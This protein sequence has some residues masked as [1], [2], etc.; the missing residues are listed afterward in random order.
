[1]SAPVSRLASGLIWRCCTLAPTTWL[2]TL[3]CIS[4]QDCDALLQ[5]L[6]KLAVRTA[7]LGPP[8]LGLA[9]LF[10]RPYARV[11]ASRSRLAAQVFSAAAAR[12]D[13]VFVDFSAPPHVAHFRTRRRKHFAVDGFHPNSA[14]YR[15]A[16][17]TAREM[18]GLQ[19]RPG[20]IG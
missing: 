19:A 15:Y 3:R 1:M 16:Y 4:L 7:W 2:P 18:L 17:T 9:P 10:P 8:N 20:L 5:E 13:V 12:H 6:D 11:M 14:T